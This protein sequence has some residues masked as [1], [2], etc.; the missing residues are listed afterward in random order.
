M[1]RE[2]LRDNDLNANIFLGKKR[3][4]YKFYIESVGVIRPEVLF[5]KALK[6]ISIADDKL[7]LQ[8]YSQLEDRWITVTQ[9]ISAIKNQITENISSTIPSYNDKL[10]FLERELDELYYILNNI[11]GIIRN[12]E[13]LNLYIERLIVLKS[14]ITVV[15]NELVTIGFISTTDT[16][17]VGELC[18]RSHKISN[19]ITEELELADL[20]KGRLNTLRQEIEDIRMNQQGFYD[21]LAHFENSAKLESAAIERA[22]NDC[23]QMKEDLVLH[24]QEIMRSRHLLHTLPTGLR[25]TVSPVM[26][27][28]DISE[29]ED[30]FVDI[31]KRLSDIENLLKNSERLTT[32]SDIDF[33]QPIQQSL[34]QQLLA[35]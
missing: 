32:E 3:N 35:A 15:E 25:M 7:Q 2:C 4:V 19:L 22:L 16:E 13:E 21:N 30:D 31:E 28:K 18:V 23:Q 9:R 10:T 14:R 17:R 27:E 11:K 24:W 33:D 12:P 5:S 26:L 8:F 29:L 34:E 6:I 20:C 1:C